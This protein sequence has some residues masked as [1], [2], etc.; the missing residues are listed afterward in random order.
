[1]LFAPLFLFYLFISLQQTSQANWAAA[2]YVGG[3]ILLA[4][5]WRNLA[6]KFAWAKWLGVAGVAIALI[7]TAALHET[8]WL[9]LPPGKDPLDRARGSRDLAMQIDAIQTKT[10]AHVTIAN[11]YM[12]AALLS[13]YLPGQP[14]TFMPVSSA[15]YNQLLLWP[16]YR[17]L[18]PTD[19]AL[20]VSDSDRVPPSLNEDF[21]TI[22]RLGQLVTRDHGRKIKSFYIYFCQRT[23]GAGGQG[24]D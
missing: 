24:A 16:S 20:F 8:I 15:P 4:A 5:K 6:A 12:T 7:E 14:T 10:G 2:A 21:P 17:E 18:R 9:H 23:P 13:F 22:E 1:A 11:K 19:N 3:L